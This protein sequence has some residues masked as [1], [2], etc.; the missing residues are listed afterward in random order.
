MIEIAGIDVAN[1]HLWR[2]S[3]YAPDGVEATPGKPLYMEWAHPLTDSEVELV[4]RGQWDGPAVFATINATEW[5]NYG[6]DD[7]CRSNE[8][9]LV[10]D[11]PESFVWLYGGH[12]SAALALP[13][14]CDDADLV[15]IIAG[16][17]DYPI[18]D[19][20]DHRELEHELAREA[21]DGY[22]QW[23]VPRDLAEMIGDN[24]T[25]V[26]EA[27]DADALQAAFWQAVEDESAEGSG[28]VFY[29]E[30]AD[31]VAWPL[32]RE[33]LERMV[34]ILSLPVPVND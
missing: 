23:D 25:D 7:L 24:G 15:R 2:L 33:L 17:E 4:K 8:R 34:R 14:T 11:Y 6:G 13:I 20:E 1:V 28:Q 5:S 29:C 27:I 32:M 31:S 30:S 12:D 21:W 16:L 26:V 10:R 9:A 18:Y 19:E 22:L 3:D